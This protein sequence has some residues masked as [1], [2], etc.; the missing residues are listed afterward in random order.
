[1]PSLASKKQCIGCS[2][3]VFVCKNAA[4]KLK[5]D[6]WGFD[7]P[8][9]DLNKCIGCG[10]CEKKCP[11]INPVN[12][13]VPYE[14][15]A[16]FCL[17]EKER[18]KSS[19][20]GLGTLLALEVVKKGGVVYGCAFMPSF[21]IQ[22]IRCVTVEEV[23]K[24]QGSK[25]VQSDIC[26]IYSQVEKDLKEKRIVLFIGTPCQIAGIKSVFSKYSNL[27][28]VDLVCH[29]VP[30]LQYLLDT[31]PRGVK[32]KALNLSFRNNTEFHFM[33]KDKLDSILY[34]RAL[35][36]DWFM[37][38][39]FNG[40]TFR[41][42]C[43]NCPFATSKRGA[44]VTIGDFWKLQSAQIKDCGKGVSLALVNTEKGGEMLNWCKGQIYSESRPLEEALAGNAQLNYPF[45][46]TLRTC[47]FRTL[48]PVLGYKKALFVALP[49]K[50]IAMKIKY[51]FKCKK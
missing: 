3:C 29:G 24:L 15:L 9:I 32:T 49:E 34:E 23:Y 45:K 2:A 39:F 10:L 28:C 48:Y 46:K 8:I 44:D 38:G 25:Y 22:H 20:G 14:T 37:K 51:Y 12:F 17:D 19:S 18:L 16:C 41:I 33:L 5:K 11:I 1:M 27:Y 31:L 6:N 42:S 26:F 43:Y 21:V 4:I 30:S 47:I 40:V 35:D 13:Y 36:N 50:V 7:Y